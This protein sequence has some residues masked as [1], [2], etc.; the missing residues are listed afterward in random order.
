M[1]SRLGRRGTTAIA[2]AAVACGGMWLGTSWSFRAASSDRGIRVVTWNLA[3]GRWGL[4]G[5]A[6]EAA[7]L[8]PDIG[9]FVEADPSRLDVRAIMKAAFPRH[10]VFLLGGGIVLV[11]RWPGGEARAYQLG[12]EKIESRIRE[13]DLTTPAG[14]WTVFSC[15]IA[16]NTLYQ[17]EPHIRE[18]AS[19]IA[20]CPNPVILAGDFNTPLDSV[21][22]DQLREIG[23]AEAFETAGSG[24]LPTWP[25]PLP[26]LSLDQIWISRHFQTISCVRNWNWRSDHAA[27]TA[28]IRATD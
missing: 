25:I 4:A 18:L 17:R 10:H 11:S 19:R 21:H 16:S 6:K 7:S 3:H 23:L 13:I 8:R 20:A 15:D 2:L 5:L 12:S 24:Y 22:L 27:V 28:T 1:R 26:V 14:V 9:I